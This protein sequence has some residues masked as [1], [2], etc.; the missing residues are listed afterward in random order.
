MASDIALHWQQES[1]LDIPELQGALE[2]RRKRGA[3]IDF[4]KLLAQPV[5]LRLRRGGEKLQIDDARPRRQLKALFQ[6]QGVPPW[7]RDRLP[8]L[9]SGERLVWVAGL[10]IDSA[11][12]ARAGVAGVVPR[13]VER[14]VSRAP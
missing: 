10:G 2:M 13:W 3:G 14:D 8:C 5:I 6:Q 9:W 1:R 12:Q 7:R 11:F 4:E